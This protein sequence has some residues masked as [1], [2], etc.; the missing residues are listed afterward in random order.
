MSNDKTQKK[1]SLYRRISELQD[2]TLLLK[3]I[4]GGLFS[5]K[6]Y[7]NDTIYEMYVIGTQALLLVS[8]GGLFSG[9]IL[10]IEAGHNLE[11]FG[12]TTLVGHTVSLGMIRELGPVITGLLLASR[13][14]AKNTSEIGAMQLSEQIEALRA[15]GINPVQKLVIP[16][17]VSAVVMFLPLT[18]V[19]DISGFLG[20]MFVTNQT[21]HI[22][23]SI[24]WDTAIRVLQM[25]D[26][27]VGLMKPIFFG[28]FISSISCYYGL[29]TSGGT[30]D[31][32]K[33]SI[34]AVVVSSVVVLALDFIF[35]KVVWEIL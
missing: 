32:G 23:Y 19:S 11:K 3:E 1:N 4:F 24:F 12:A 20:G 34:N 33:K 7:I 31:L 25:K 15:F 18:L 13:T 27:F 21:F 22:D 30:N 35:T 16:R 2:Y 17:I 5:V 26:L 28:F 29:T 14:G 8:L 10:A 6:R 9:I